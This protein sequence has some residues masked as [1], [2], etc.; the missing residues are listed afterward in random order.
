MPTKPQHRNVMVDLETLGVRPGCAVLSIGAVAF[1]SRGAARRTFYRVVSRNSCASL[2]LAEEPATLKWWE[3]QGAAAREVFALAG[4]P[5]ALPLHCALAQFRKYLASVCS[6]PLI[7]G[8]GADFDKPILEAAYAAIGEGPP[9]RPYSGRCYRTLKNFEPGLLAVKMG[10][11]HNALDDAITQAH[12]A[13]AL[14]ASLGVE[15]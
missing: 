10:T 12:H 9:W 11:A 13:V 3:G 7:W 14:A 6:E 2:G 4:L 15:L 1:S 5:K 8:N